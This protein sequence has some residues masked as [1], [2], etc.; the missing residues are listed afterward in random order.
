M[1][2]AWS[3]SLISIQWHLGSSPCPAWCLGTGIAFAWLILLFRILEVPGLD[4]GPEMCFIPCF[5]QSL[6]ADVGPE[7]QSGHSSLASCPIYDLL[8]K[9]V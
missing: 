4:L 3:L 9:I 8:N 1:A 5:V 6:H 2:M 7:P